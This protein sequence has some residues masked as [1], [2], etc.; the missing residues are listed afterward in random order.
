M[1]V[2]VVGTT[3]SKLLK[4]ERKVAKPPGFK[5]EMRSILFGSCASCT[6]NFP[7]ASN[8]LTGSNRA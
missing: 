7:N 8:V 4:P 5:H 1:L 6:F 3:L 2:Q